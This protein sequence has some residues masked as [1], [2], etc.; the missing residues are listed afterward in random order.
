MA[1]SVANFRDNLQ[2]GG[3]RPSLFEVQVTDPGLGIGLNVNKFA[4]SC[5]AAQLPESTIGV[6]EVPYFGRTVKV[7]GDRTFAE[8][9]VTIIN[10]EDFNVYDAHMRWMDRINK[11]LHSV[12]VVQLL[13]QLHIPVMLLF[14]T[15]LKMVELF[16]Q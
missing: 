14:A 6:I 1:F 10:D 9:T 11:M 8:W 13:I 7:A 16:K 2:F 15:T 5:K 12:L 4:F 3:A